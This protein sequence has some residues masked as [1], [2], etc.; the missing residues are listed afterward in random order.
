MQGPL[1]WAQVPQ[2]VQGQIEAFA[3]ADSSGAGEQERIGSQIV[4]SS[5]FLLQELIL[6]QREGT[7][8]IVRLGREILTTNEVGGKGV[9]VGGQILQQSPEKN[10]V[11]NAT[12]VAQGRLFFAQPTE[13]TEEMRIAAELR[14]PANLR[15]GRTEIGK[16]APRGR[17]IV[18]YRASPPGQGE[19]LELCLEDLF[20]T[21]GGRVEPGA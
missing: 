1:V 12:Y 2:A 9:A 18:V 6:L 7:G 4:G 16:E 8:Q 21:G 19:R 5:Q 15:K 20:E 14:E 10:E 11:F 3:D 13:P 17:S